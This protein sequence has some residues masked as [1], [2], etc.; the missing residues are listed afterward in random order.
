M[1]RRAQGQSIPLPRVLS[2]TTP[3]HDYS[4]DTIEL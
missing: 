2:S 1:G 4:T 3:L